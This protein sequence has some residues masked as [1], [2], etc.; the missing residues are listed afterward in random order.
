MVQ[1]VT[2][3][4]NMSKTQMNQIMKKR[5]NTKTGMVGIGGKIVRQ[6]TNCV[7]WRS[8]CSKSG[9][10]SIWYLPTVWNQSL[11]LC[12]FAGVRVAQ[13]DY[14]NRITVWILP[15]GTSGKLKETQ[16]RSRQKGKTAFCSRKTKWRKKQ[17]SREERKNVL[18]NDFDN[19]VREEYEVNSFG[20]M[21]TIILTA[22]K[23][24]RRIG[25]TAGEQCPL[26]ITRCYGRMLVDYGGSR[27]SMETIR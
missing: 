22:C 16:E 2:K 1:N 14:T 3:W 23:S 11:T 10:Y 26:S 17:C 6:T 7:N 13:S 15:P 24:R 19:T 8:T 27:K 9:C 5:G 12:H 20:K 25:S 4:I 18:D 21:L